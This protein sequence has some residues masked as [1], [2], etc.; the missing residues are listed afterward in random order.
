M[1][2]TTKRIPPT[3]NSKTLSTSVRNKIAPRITIPII[4]IPIL[5]M[6][7]NLNYISEF[8]I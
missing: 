1:A 5:F 2:A 8:A 4:I 3:K 6:N 7:F